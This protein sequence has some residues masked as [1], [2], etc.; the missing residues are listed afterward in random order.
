M[1][2]E[3]LSLEETQRALRFRE[4]RDRRRYTAARAWRRQVLAGYL[5]ADPR[6]VRF[7]EG[8]DGKPALASPD[9]SWLRFSA[10][11]SNGLAALVV[12]RGREVGVD[13]ERVH[14]DFPVDAVV[15]R[16]FSLHE[17]QWLSVLAPEPR[18]DAFF[19]LWTLKEAS[20]KAMGTGLRGSL[21]ELSSLPDLGQTVRVVGAKPGTPGGGIWSV[22]AF[23][24]VRGYR[25]AVSIQGDDVPLPA[26][27]RER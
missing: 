4:A 20:L 7:I 2:S 15:R 8:H 18:T 11:R 1:K 5:G 19:T 27:S 22:R 10:S 6:E 3:T 24:T 21:P 23:D 14:A 12:T 16:F 9:G 17:Q 25:G 13:V 26:H